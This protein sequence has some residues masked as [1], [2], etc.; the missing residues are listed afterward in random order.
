MFSQLCLSIFTEILKCFE[1]LIKCLFSDSYKFK[2]VGAFLSGSCAP[3]PVVG[4]FL[5]REK[6][7][8]VSNQVVEGRW[9]HALQGF[10][11]DGTSVRAGMMPDDG[12]DALFRPIRTVVLAAE[13][14]QPKVTQ[15]GREMLFKQGGCLVI[16]QMAV[17]SGNAC[18]EISG[19]R[20]GL[21]H[22]FVIVG[23]EHQVICGRDVGEGFVGHMSQVGHE[24][25]AP[26]FGFQA[27]TY[28]V[29]AVVRQ[30]EGFDVKAGQF[31]R[32]SGCERMCGVV[33]RLLPGTIIQGNSPVRAR[34]GIDRDMQPLTQTRQTLDVVGMVVG[35]EDGMYVA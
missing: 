20:A 24:H 1:M 9:R 34:R 17:R 31:K 14:A 23:L 21:E 29:H 16:G 26:T 15:T 12:G 5:N 3:F 19:I 10:D 25:Q 27:I 7:G 11:N 8:R 13:V 35:D 30:L 22:F 4:L 18:L 2:N 6:A 32:L 28:A 33:Q